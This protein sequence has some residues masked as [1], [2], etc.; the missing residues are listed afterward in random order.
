MTKDQ[1]IAQMQICEQTQGLSVLDHG[2]QVY[3][4]FLELKSGNTDGWRLPSWYSSDMLEF[5]P[6]ASIMEEYMIYHDCGKPYCVYTDEEGK[7]HFP[8]H[9]RVSSSIWRES[10]GN[11]DACVL[12]ERDMDMHLM[13]PSAIQFYDRPDLIPTL[14]ISALCEIHANAQMFGGIESTSFKI[15]WKNLERLGKSFLK[16]I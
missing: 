7:R 13:K 16:N 2:K 9:A 6:D 14:L 3:S 11:E 10:G 15:K 4:K 1:I 8:D 12:M 5:L